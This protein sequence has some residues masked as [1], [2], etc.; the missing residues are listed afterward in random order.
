MSKYREMS[1]LKKGGNRGFGASKYV[2][3][4]KMYEIGLRQAKGT[5]YVYGWMTFA[6]CCPGCG[7][8]NC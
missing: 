2:L 7:F 3:C 5:V 4:G 1:T 6:I 8:D